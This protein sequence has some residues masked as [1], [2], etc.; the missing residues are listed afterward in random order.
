M[1]TVADVPGDFQYRM[2]SYGTEKDEWMP[3]L[4]KKIPKDQLALKYGGVSD[5]KP[6]EFHG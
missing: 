4:L 5:F 3:K 2:E 1:T 6:V